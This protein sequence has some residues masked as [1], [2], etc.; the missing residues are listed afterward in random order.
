MTDE[1]A[2]TPVLD[3]L[4]EM[5]VASLEHNMLSPRELMLVRL[6]ALIAVDAPPASYLLNAEPAAD[7]GVTGDDVLGVMIGVAPVVGGPR[8]VAASGNIMRAFGFAVAVAEADLADDT[9]DDDGA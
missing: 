1:T 6:A 8:V 3:T 2:E 7:A 4:A 9:D 5:T